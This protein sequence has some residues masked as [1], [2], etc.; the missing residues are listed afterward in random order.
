[1]KKI[2]FVRHGKSSW[3]HDVR[4][5]NRPLKKSGITDVNLVCLEFLKSDIKPKKIFS[6]PANRALETCKI[7]MKNMSFSSENVHVFEE[8]YDFGGQ[9]VVKFVKSLDNELDNVMIF[10]H[11]HAFTS[12]VNSF[13]SKYIDNVPTSGLIQI[14]F[15]INEWH[16]IVRGITVLTI[17]PRNLR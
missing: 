6:S 5:I 3:K 1:M 11:N 10:G 13:G 2:T 15:D 14:S 12:I 16:N 8:L 17:F 7:F 9:N 4:D